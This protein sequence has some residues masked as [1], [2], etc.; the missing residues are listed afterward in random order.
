MGIIVDLARMRARARGGIL[1][2]P[3]VLN[4]ASVNARAR[5]CVVVVVVRASPLKAGEGEEGVLSRPVLILFSLTVLRLAV[6]VRQCCCDAIV[7]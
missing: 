1:P 5:A 3:Q 7:A 4:P 2:G 6:R